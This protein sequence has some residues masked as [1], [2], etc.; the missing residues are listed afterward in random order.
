MSLYGWFWYHTE[1]WIKDRTARRP[2]TFILRDFYHASPIAWTFLMFLAGYLAYSHL[3]WKDL[4]LVSTG[5]LLG[6]LFW[7]NSWKEGEQEYPTYNPNG[8]LK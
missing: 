3:H 8:S 4:L 6:H 1:F 2:Y 5:L 7:G